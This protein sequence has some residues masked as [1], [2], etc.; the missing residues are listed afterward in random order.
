M[1]FETIEEWTVERRLDLPFS[2]LNW[3]PQISANIPF[4]AQIE[5]APSAVLALGL[6]GAFLYFLIT[7][8]F[9]LEWDKV[10]GSSDPLEATMTMIDMGSASEEIEPLPEQGGSGTLTAASAPP[11]ALDA[12]VET[13]L[14]PEWSVGRVRIARAIPTVP[15]VSAGAGKAQG[16]GVGA[17]NSDG[18]YDPYAGAAPKRDPEKDRAFRTKKAEPSLVGRLA[19]LLGIGSGENASGEQSFDAWVAQLKQRLPRARGSVEL[20]AELAPDGTIKSAKIIGGSASPQVKF[21]VRSAAV[22]ERFNDIGESG[23]QVIRLPLVRLG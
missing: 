11:S 15:D 17:G 8:A 9:D 16:S 2:S 18:V 4:R 20:S 10:T 22:G 12:S 5:K 23:Q 6:N 7:S 14:P 19:G 1:A 21:F 3:S 13:E